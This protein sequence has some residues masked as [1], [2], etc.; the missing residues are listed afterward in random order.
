MAQ[1]RTRAYGQETCVGESPA[2]TVINTPAEGPDSVPI[3]SRWCI[4]QVE[5]TDT[6]LY[7]IGE[8]YC[9]LFSIVNC[10]KIQI[11]AIDDAYPRRN[12]LVGA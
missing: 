5:L 1:Y 4:R 3:L 12:H 8:E 2:I 11:G 10:C 7:V 6:R 9:R